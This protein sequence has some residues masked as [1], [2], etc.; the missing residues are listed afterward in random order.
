MCVRLNIC[1]FC[2]GHPTKHEKSGAPQASLRCSLLQHLPPSSSGGSVPVDFVDSLL[3]GRHPKPAS[4][5]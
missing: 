2:M 3:K 4:Q 5:E 1:A